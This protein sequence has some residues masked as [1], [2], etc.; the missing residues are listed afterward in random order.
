MV[1]LDVV[2]LA[3][4]RDTPERVKLFFVSV[5][6]K[7]LLIT[8]LQKKSVESFPNPETKEINK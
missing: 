3:R 8:T 4:P 6:P 5:P 2:N 7:P 1:W